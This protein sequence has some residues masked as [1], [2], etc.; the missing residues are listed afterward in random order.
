MPHI[1]TTPVS[2]ELEAMPP[3]ILNP[4]QE[5][6]ASPNNPEVSSFTR[7]GVQEHAPS[8]RARLGRLAVVTAFTG[9]ALFGGAH[10]AEA[11][12]PEAA[13]TST[14][15]E[16]H[17]SGVNWSA[18]IPLA[19]GV[20]GGLGAATGIATGLVGLR[21]QTKEKRED[22][23]GDSL[24]EVI[25]PGSTG[26]ERHM[27]LFNLGLFGEHSSYKPKVFDAC[28]VYLRSRKGELGKLKDSFGKDPVA[29]GYAITDRR[30]ADREAFGMLVDT[31]P[32]ARRRLR[33]EN[34]RLRHSGRPIDDLAELS[35]ITGLSPDADERLRVNARAINLDDMRDIK[36]VSLR[37]VDLTGVGMQRNQV[38]RV[39]L[40]NARLSEGQFAGTIFT[41]CDIREL[42]ARSAYLNGA[43]FNRCLVD[44]NTKFGNLPDN[45][46]DARNGALAPKDPDGYRGDGRVIL[47]DLRSKTLT[48]QQI[49]DLVK[50]WQA[51]GLTL[52][53]GSDQ[54][55]LLDPTKTPP[56]L[57]LPPKKRA[58]K[59]P[60]PASAD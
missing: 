35:E 47:R 24:R 30:N 2:P 13:V 41:G 29:L 55:Y 3:D 36:N 27:R 39:S 7:P 40:R 38:T 48:K 4:M 54:D 60:D 44:T 46:P 52:L 8:A 50:Q 58:S 56:K 51:N 33:K 23:F 9:I 25:K 16:T 45:H 14:Q 19:L 28:V 10:P 42:D 34:S 43:E 15:T 49:I 53:E 31:L 6:V 32:A 21:N 18:D 12:A 5:V 22:R 26:E 1:E 20:V 11:A 57:K 59:T 17:H 37:N